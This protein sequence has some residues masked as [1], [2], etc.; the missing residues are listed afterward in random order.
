MQEDAIQ[1][2]IESSIPDSKA[3]VEV[4][5][6]HV[7]VVVISPS[8]EGLNAVKKQQMVYAGLNESI[9]SGAIHAVHINAFTPSEWE[10]QNA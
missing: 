3:N 4:D 7:K 6:S 5:G 8:F 10:Q 1:S 2:M 9:A